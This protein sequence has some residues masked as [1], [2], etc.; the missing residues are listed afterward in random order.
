MLLHSLKKQRGHFF[1]SR[2]WVGDIEDITWPYLV[3]HRGHV[4][5]FPPIHRSGDRQKEMILECVPLLDPLP[6][7]AS[8][9]FPEFCIGLQE[10]PQVIEGIYK[11]L[12]RRS[13][14]CC[15][16][17]RTHKVTKGVH[18]H[19]EVMLPLEVFPIVQFNHFKILLPHC[20]PQTFFILEKK[21]TSCDF[22]FYFKSNPSSLRTF[23]WRGAMAIDGCTLPEA[24]VHISQEQWGFLSLG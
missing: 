2:L 16:S 14:I 11:E 24:I 22:S 19:G 3:F 8:H 5:S 21:N 4:A 6:L 12:K 13:T 1:P 23:W 10:R 20:S 9:P 7:K 17:C 18:G 15:Y